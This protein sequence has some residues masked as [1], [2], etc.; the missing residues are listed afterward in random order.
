MADEDKDSKTEEASGKRL[1]EA[2]AKGQFARSPEIAVVF[3]LSGCSRGT[4]D[5]RGHRRAGHLGDGS[6]HVQPAFDHSASARHSSPAA[7]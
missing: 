2:H 4:F 3:L 7:G 6:Q 5:D 1:S